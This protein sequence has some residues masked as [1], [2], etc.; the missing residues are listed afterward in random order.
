MVANIKLQ[1]IFL[2]DVL[3]F[4]L[5]YLIPTI[6]H[7]LAFPLYL[8]DPMRLAILG[9]AFFMSEKWN[10]YLLALTLPLF[11]Y[12][13]GGHPVVWKSIIIGVELTANLIILSVLEREIGQTFV[14]ILL[15]IVVSKVEYYAL[16][17]GLITLGLLER[18]LLATELVWQISVALLISAVYVFV[19][20]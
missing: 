17:Y 16:K 18:E 11:S 19:R 9:S 14:T 1:R 6:S 13:V 3:I 2:S 12:F 8:L 10:A 5:I 4:G 7:L 20:R 15:S